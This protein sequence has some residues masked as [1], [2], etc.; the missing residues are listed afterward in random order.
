MRPIWA[1]SANDTAAGVALDPS[2]NIYVTGQTQSANFPTVN[3]L[4]ATSSESD[5]FVVKM[6]ASGQVH[7]STYLGG[8]GLNNGTAIAADAAGNAYV[9]G[10]TERVRISRSP[11]THIRRVNNGSYDAFR[12]HSQRLWKQRPVTQPIWAAP[13]RISVMGSRWTAPVNIYIAG[14]TISMIS[15][16]MRPRSRHTM[17]AAMRLWPHSITS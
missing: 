10:F 12:S 4:Q 11:P 5:A 2:G 9:T 17:A 16:R 8:T 6:N 15:R 1:A 7:Y 14:S 3:P 13:G